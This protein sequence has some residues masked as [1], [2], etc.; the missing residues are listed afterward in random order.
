MPRLQQSLELEIRK[1]KLIDKVPVLLYVNENRKLCVVE[2]LQYDDSI[3][4]EFHSACYLPERAFVVGHNG[5]NLDESVSFISTLT[6]K[7]AYFYRRGFFEHEFLQD[8]DFRDS[9][10]IW[11][12]VQQ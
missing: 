10:S 11:Y 5:F 9:Q 2:T 12:F 8:G 3:T 6:P 4:S 1:L 7:E